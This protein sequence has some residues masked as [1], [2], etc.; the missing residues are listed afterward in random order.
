MN[1]RFFKSFNII[2]KIRAKTHLIGKGRTL[3]EKINI[4]L[5]VCLSI[6]HAFLIRIS[7]KSE[8]LQRIKLPAVIE[9]DDLKYYVESINHLHYIT[10]PF[11]RYE[12]CIVKEL[13]KNGIFVDVGA[14]IGTHGLNS[15]AECVFIEANPT[16]AK[17]LKKNIELNN[18]KATLYVC[19]AWSEN[20]RLRFSAEVFSGIGRV[21]KDGNI[22]VKA[23]T[24][25][26]LK[27]K[28]VS[29]L[30]IDVEGAELEVLKGARSLLRKKPIIMF[31][32]LSN[33]KLE[34]IKE[35][36]SKK[37]YLYFYRVNYLTYLAS[38]RDISKKL[39]KC[40][41]KKH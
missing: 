10:A 31:E 25:D 1:D 35:F 6:A 14:Y 12:M 26:S 8:V 36:L 34:E 18:K 20:T 24:L 19:A 17:I 40:F 21:E 2:D 33:K 27:L 37:G 4:F 5:L 38:P 16:N 23:I 29:M 32:A 41:N 3:K 15:K 39:S 9:I 7:K 30:K 22:E 11:E 28:N 13:S